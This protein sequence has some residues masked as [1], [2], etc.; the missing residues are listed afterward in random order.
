MSS[1]AIETVGKYP[2]QELLDILSTG[3]EWSASNFWAQIEKYKWYW[4]YVCDEKGEPLYPDKIN[5]ELTPD[6]VLL[7]V[8][9]HEYD[10]G[11][12]IY[13]LQKVDDQLVAMQHR[14][15][16]GSVTT[17]CGL[18]CKGD[19]WDYTSYNAIA[20]ECTTC[21]KWV[22]ITLANLADATDWA[23]ENYNHLFSYSVNN[24]G[25]RD[26]I[27]YDVIGADVIIQKIVLGEVTYG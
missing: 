18:D 22:D 19:D 24:K 27:D 1:T 7:R 4:W 11:R 25:I 13:F 17:I 26:E 2:T 14:S 9:E 21:I 16:D 20:E 15:E 5:P 6:T 10:T 23:L 12:D 8:R 3:V